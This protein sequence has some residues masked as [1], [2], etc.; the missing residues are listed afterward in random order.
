MDA[1]LVF[2]QNYGN[3]VLIVLGVVIGLATYV[4][5][6][7]GK[8]LAKLVVEFLL[9]LATA[10]WDS[11]TEKQV[12]DIAGLVYDG[13]RDWAGPSWLRVIP[14]RL[15]ITR[16]SVQNWAWA[17]WQHLH[18]WYGSQLAQ[19]VMEGAQAARVVPGNLR[20]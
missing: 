15:F 9:G 18:K 11:I 5:R 6:G 19:T 16:E 17:A 8:Q 3:L 13:A 14:W 10:G 1:L 20:L 7:E 4:A 2:W 12:R